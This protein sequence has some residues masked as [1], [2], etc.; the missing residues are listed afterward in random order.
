VPFDSYLSR[1]FQEILQKTSKS[2]EQ[3]TIEPNGEWH[4]DGDQNA[5]EQKTNGYQTANGADDDS[6][7]D[8][9]IEIT[10]PRTRQIK[11]EAPVTPFSLNTPSVGSREASVSTAPGSISRPQVGQKRKSE[12]IDLTLSDDDEPPR[13]NKRQETSYNTPNSIP[14]QRNNN[15]YQVLKYSNVMRA[16]G[17][18]GVSFS[19]VRPPSLTP[20]S[21][22]PNQPQQSTANGSIPLSSPGMRPA[23]LN[24]SP[25][26]FS[27]PPN[28][29]PSFSNPGPFPPPPRP[30][31]YQN[32]RPMQQFSPADQQRQSSLT[33]THNLDPNPAYQNP[34]IYLPQP[35]Q[36]G[37]SVD[38]QL[39]EFLMRQGATSGR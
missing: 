32:G 23:G 34:D 17:A 30:Q 39:R 10:D 38:R 28:R 33:H 35:V 22:P 8:D 27:P 12:V 11:Q 4:V 25:S 5:R 37:A 3:V 36:G 2:T 13:P 7:D 29:T 19:V 20:L 14:D 1:Y 24:I 16:P 26:P 21:G 6:D 18:N 9:L 31:G 15:G